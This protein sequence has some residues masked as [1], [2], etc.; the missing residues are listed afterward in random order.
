MARYWK[1]LARNRSDNLHTEWHYFVHVCSFTFIFT[2]VTQIEEYRKHF[3]QKIRPASA[4]GA[5]RPIWRCADGTQ[6]T[7]HPGDHWERQSRFD[8]LPLYL[9]EEPKRQ[10]IVK[11]LERAIREFSK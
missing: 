8:V 10:K 11:A 5:N 9:F 4:D 1:E 2:T 6:L 7:R 3:A